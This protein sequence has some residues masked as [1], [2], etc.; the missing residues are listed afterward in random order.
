MKITVNRKKDGLLV[1]IDGLSTFL[2]FAA[3]GNDLSVN[4]AKA[5]A[6][7]LWNL[8]FPCDEIESD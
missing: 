2:S 4:E 8:Q 1:T 7:E 6:I 3:Y 5:T